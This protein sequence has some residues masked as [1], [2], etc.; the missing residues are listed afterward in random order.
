MLELRKNKK[1][2]LMLFLLVVPIVIPFFKK[3]FFLTDDGEWMVVRLTDFHRSVVS[4][5]IPVRWASR[6]NF[7]FGYPVF[8]F[9]YPLSLYVGEIFHLVGLSFVSSIKAV[10]VISFL[11]SAYFMFLFAKEVWGKLGGFFSALLYVYVPYR[12]LDVYVRGS[13]G[14]VVALTFVPLVF[15]G[16]KL[17]SDGK[18]KNRGL[19]IG[20]VAFAC[21]VASHNIIAMLFAPFIIGYSLYL[22]LGSKDR[23]MA[24]LNF[25]FFI[26]LSLL[27]SCFFWLPALYDKQFTILDQTSVA[28]YWEHYPTIQQLIV[29][30]WGYGPSIVGDNDKPSYQIGIV[31]LAVVVLSIFFI[32]KKVIKNRQERLYSILSLTMFIVSFALMCSFSRQVWSIVPVLWRA[33][34][35]WRLLSLTM[36]SSAFLG[37]LIGNWLFK[38]LKT[39]GVILFTLVVLF[40]YFSYAKPET[41]VFREDGYY[42]TNEATTTVLD[43]YMPIWAKEKPL[44][45]SPG[46]I[47]LSDDGVASDLFYNSR[48]VKFIFEG[49]KQAKVRFNVLYFPGWS[50]RIDG[51]QQA[52]SYDN[53]KGLIEAKIPEGTHKVSLSFGET[54]IRLFSD[55]LSLFGMAVVCLISFGRIKLR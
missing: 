47:E 23:K 37:G 52:I 8:D 42:S 22:F 27:L 10:F 53:Q 54:P 3:G 16:M 17:L 28:N 26:M 25:G 14:E 32:V 35:P 49:K 19:I 4:G 6:L 18:K 7:G 34:F 12:F 48:V 36:F 40:S 55:L 15:Y 43:E 9:L 46:K 29:P 20:S 2:L 44:E 30:K 11:F 21:L 24:F 51:I 41:Y 45:H 5:Q 1:Y 33:Q 13:I 39:F 31:H 38:K 50:L